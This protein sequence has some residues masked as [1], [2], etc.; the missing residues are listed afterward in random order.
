MPLDLKSP[1]DVVVW[2]SPAADTYRAYRAAVTQAAA[3]LLG[4][5]DAAVTKLNL[6]YDNYVGS[7]TQNTDNLT[8]K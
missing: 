1:K 3:N 2:D 6:T 7:E 4:V 8:P 5:L